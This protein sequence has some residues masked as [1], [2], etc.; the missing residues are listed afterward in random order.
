MKYPLPQLLIC[1]GSHAKQSRALRNSRR[2][3]STTRLVA[4]DEVDLVVQPI[5]ASDQTID[6]ELSDATGDKRRHI[7]LLQS[8]FGG[9]LGLGQLP[10]FE[11]PS[12]GFSKPRSANTLP[13]LAVTF[14]SLLIPVPSRRLGHGAN[15]EMHAGLVLQRA[16][17]A[18]QVLGGWVAARSE[19]AHQAL[20][21]TAEHFT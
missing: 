12:S 15:F 16:D 13:R 7:R 17:D 18:K 9:S 14:L 5:Q 4:H 6:R 1:R 20:L 8:K 2:R 3:S 10:A 21:G 11:N 19:H